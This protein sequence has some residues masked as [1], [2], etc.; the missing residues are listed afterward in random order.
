MLLLEVLTGICLILKNIAD[1]KV[2]ELK[3]MKITNP[4]VT[5]ELTG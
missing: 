2:A 5:Y 1:S 4:V 3:K